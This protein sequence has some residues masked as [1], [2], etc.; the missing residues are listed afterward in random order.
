MDPYVYPGTH[1]LRNKFNIQDYAHWKRLEGIISSTK[2]IELRESASHTIKKF[3]F[4]T[5]K[6]IHRY[7]FEDIYTW[8][9]SIRT[10][11][12][13]KDTTMFCPPEFIPSYADEIF[14][15]LRNHNFFRSYPISDLAIGL[16][17]LFC[18]INM[19][20][21]FREGNGRTQREFL[22]LLSA[23]L[24]YHLDL[25]LVDKDMYYFASQRSPVSAQPMI[26]LIKN[27][28]R[29]PPLE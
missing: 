17:Q 3:D 19:L 24:G 1:I 27:S 5:L 6:A 29:E 15:K 4:H 20:H 12:L 10:V 8:A 16:G 2:I 22:Y 25:N 14:S 7:L 28:L 13:A 9:G 21:P 23:T 11:P 26:E 18:D